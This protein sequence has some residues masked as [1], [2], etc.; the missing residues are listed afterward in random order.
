MFS[1]SKFKVLA[2][3]SY[4]CSGYADDFL[5]RESLSM[6]EKQ[7]PVKWENRAVRSSHAPHHHLWQGMVE[8][9]K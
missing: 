5:P 1:K 8:P 3:I 4:E 9:R 2:L 7:T 6:K